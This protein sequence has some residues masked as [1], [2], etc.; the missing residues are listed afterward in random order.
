VPETKKDKPIA[1]DAYEKLADAYS[2]RA[3]FLCIRARKT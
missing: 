2:K 1:L 3:T